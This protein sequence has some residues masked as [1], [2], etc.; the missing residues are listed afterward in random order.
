MKRVQIALVAAILLAG[1]SL[2]TDEKI[3]HWISN[4]NITIICETAFI[5]GLNRPQITSIDD[6]YVSFANG[7]RVNINACKVHGHISVVSNAYDTENTAIL[8]ERLSTIQ[9]RPN[10]QFLMSMAEFNKKVAAKT[11][12]Q[13]NG[14]NM[15]K[16][17]M[18]TLFSRD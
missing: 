14:W 3:N 10:K 7:V 6:K 11:V 18:S 4:N 13:Q 5:N 1:C 15:L 17:G 9:F 8:K 16:Y 2:N 12:A